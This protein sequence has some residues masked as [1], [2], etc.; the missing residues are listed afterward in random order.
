LTREAAS[1][2]ESERDQK[3]EWGTEEIDGLSSLAIVT[4][5]SQLTMVEK[6]KEGME[7]RGREKERGCEKEKTGN[8]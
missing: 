1:G 8:T 6:R 3:G 4:G 5:L 2:K 7:Q